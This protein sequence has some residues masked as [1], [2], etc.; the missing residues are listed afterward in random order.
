MVQEAFFVRE[1]FDVAFNH[2]AEV[3]FVVWTRPLFE[4][5]LAL[6]EGEPPVP[7]ACKV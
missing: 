5:R 2:E 4:A 7:A 6:L 3:V 1:K